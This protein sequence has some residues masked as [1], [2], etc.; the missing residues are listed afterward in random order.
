MTK[1]FA[2]S[3]SLMPSRTFANGTANVETTLD[4]CKMTIACYSSARPPP[5]RKGWEEVMAAI[6]KCQ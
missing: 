3:L 1:A 6:S 4:L 5:Y 2:Q